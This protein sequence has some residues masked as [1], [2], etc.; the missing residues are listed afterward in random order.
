MPDQ[1]C[2]IDILRS[3]SALLMAI[4]NSIAITGNIDAMREINSLV[5]VAQIETNRRLAGLTSR[6]S[7]LSKTNRD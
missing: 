6:Q 5:A 7:G 3:T 1:Q 2:H 4:R